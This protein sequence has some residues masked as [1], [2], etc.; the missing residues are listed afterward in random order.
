MPAGRRRYTAP[1]SL[2]HIHESNHPNR[3]GISAL[4]LSSAGVAQL[5]AELS[6]IDAMLGGFS[7]AQENNRDVVVVAR[8]E[9]RIFVDVDFREARVEFFQEGGNLRLGFFAKMAAG[10]RVDRHIAGRGELQSAVFGADICARL[11]RRAQ[12]SSLDQA[13]H[14]AIHNRGVSQVGERSHA[15]A[16]AI[17]GGQDF[18]H[19][20]VHSWNNLYPILIL[21]GSIPGRLPNCSSLCPSLFSV[22][23]GFRVCASRKNSKAFNTKNTEEHRENLRRLG[24]CWQLRRSSWMESLPLR[25]VLRRPAWYMGRMKVCEV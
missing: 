3:D 20:R 13:R 10:A 6:G 17:E 12:P 2:M 16:R 5:A 8:A 1:A 25:L 18:L 4:T 11:M 22:V 15:R 19:Q 14:S 21:S 9:I 23:K 7:R 24:K